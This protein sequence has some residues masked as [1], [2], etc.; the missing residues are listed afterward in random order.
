M[1]KV[2]KFKEIME[3]VKQGYNVY[4]KNKGYKVIL[5]N[6]KFYVIFTSNNNMAGLFWV[7]GVTSSYNENDFFGE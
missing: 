6:D 7:D 1:T 2:M 5:D 3:N 4:W